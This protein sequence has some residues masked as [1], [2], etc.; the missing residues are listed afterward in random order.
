MERNATP[1]RDHKRKAG[2][3]QP[4]GPFDLYIL[5]SLRPHLF[6]A[7][8]ERAAGGAAARKRNANCRAEIRRRRARNFFCSGRRA[9]KGCRREA[10]IGRRP[11]HGGGPSVSLAAGGGGGRATRHAALPARLRLLHARPPFCRRRDHPVA[12]AALRPAARP[13]G[14]PSSV[15]VVRRR[16]RVAPAFPQRPGALQR[17]GC[18]LRR[19]RRRRRSPARCGP[20]PARRR[21]RGSPGAPNV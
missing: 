13:R 14:F 15:H 12:C 8:R 10:L 11:V 20:A 6:Q 9:H 18:Q 2:Q 16:V 19:R 3:A 4:P 7:Q 17:V 1:V 5:A 21:A